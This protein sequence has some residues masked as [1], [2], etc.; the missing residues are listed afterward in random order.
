MVGEEGGKRRATPENAGERKEKEESEETDKEVVV[1]RGEA[2]VE[3]ATVWSEKN[4][5]KET[6]KDAGVGEAEA[7]TATEDEIGRKIE[8]REGGEDVEE[9]EKGVDAEG[10]NVVEEVNDGPGE[11]ISEAGGMMEGREGV[12]EDIGGG[13][14][15]LEQVFARGDDEK[16][17]NKEEDNGERIEGEGEE[18]LRKA[19]RGFWAGSGLMEFCAGFLAILHKTIIS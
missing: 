6:R 5:E 2:G 8:N 15:A 18:F 1:N 12:A 11:H 4:K 13:G 9:A 19:S 10:E 7:R 16:I 14:S 3:N 17:A